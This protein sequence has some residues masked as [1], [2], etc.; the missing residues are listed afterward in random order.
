LKINPVYFAL[1]VFAVL[2]AL[3]VLVMVVSWV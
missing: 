2:V 1:L 3:G